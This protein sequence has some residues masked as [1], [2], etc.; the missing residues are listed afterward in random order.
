MTVRYY[1]QV[2]DYL[3]PHI[4]FIL[5][6]RY[7]DIIDLPLYYGCNRLNRNGTRKETEYNLG[8]QCIVHKRY[9]KETKDIYKGRHFYWTKIYDKNQLQTF[10]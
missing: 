10:I 3:H 2:K 5:Y 6:Y 4:Q 9:W 7:G 1:K 8:Y